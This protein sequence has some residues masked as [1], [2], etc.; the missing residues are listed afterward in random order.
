MHRRTL[1]TRSALPPT[2]RWRA[3]RLRNP[4]RHQ[5]LRQLIRLAPASERRD[6]VVRRQR[7]VAGDPE[8]F[9]DPDRFDITRWPNKHVAFGSGIHTCLGAPLSRLEAQ[10]A[11]AYL[12]ETFGRIEVL[13]PRIRYVPN[14]VSRGPLD[15]EVQFHM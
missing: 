9:A 8:A 13:T 10:E 5:P 4:R 2:D 15:V 12:A 3:K 14:L 11:F 1:P 6:R 7:Q